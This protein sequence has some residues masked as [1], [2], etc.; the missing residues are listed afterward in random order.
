ML[1]KEDVGVPVVGSLLSFA[2]EHCANMRLYVARP[3]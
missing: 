3:R 2:L 1:I